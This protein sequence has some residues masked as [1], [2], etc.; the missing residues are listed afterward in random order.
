[1]VWNNYLWISKLIEYSIQSAKE[2]G[3]AQKGDKAIVILGSNEEDPDQGDILQIKDINW[4][5]QQRKQKMMSFP[6]DG[7][8]HKSLVVC[9]SF[10]QWKLQTLKTRLLNI[11]IFFLRN[12]LFLS[13]SFVLFFLFYRC[14]CAHHSWLNNSELSSTFKGKGR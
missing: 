14:C 12:Y 11:Q 2:Q 4:Q 10:K 13:L 7:S 6:F 8:R 9:M 5:Q 1:M 3:F